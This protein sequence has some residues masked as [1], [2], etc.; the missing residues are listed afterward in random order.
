MTEEEFEM[1]REKM[2]S[3]ETLLRRL[4][5]IEHAIWAVALVAGFA[6]ITVVYLVA[7]YITN[8]P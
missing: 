2:Q 7:R 5:G 4:L 6:A 3:T 1:Y 8:G